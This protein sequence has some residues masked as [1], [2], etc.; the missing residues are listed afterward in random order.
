MSELPL[1]MRIQ[2]KLA[3]FQI[4]PILGVI[5]SVF[6][7]PVSL[8]QL[9]VG[10]VGYC[11]GSP[12]AAEQLTDSWQQALYALANI[13]TASFLGLLLEGNVH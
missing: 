13:C 4:I 2:R 11:T 9:V 10:G 7:F 5:P 3:F 1:L 8:C 12:W 6:K